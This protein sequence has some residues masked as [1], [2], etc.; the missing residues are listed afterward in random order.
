MT[1]EEIQSIL[2]SLGEV[3]FKSFLR[4]CTKAAARGPT[5]LNGAK[6][7]DTILREFPELPF[8][9]LDLYDQMDL[10]RQFLSALL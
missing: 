7:M 1:R 3:R 8:K 2:V 4:L 5:V 9:G 6:L 10:L